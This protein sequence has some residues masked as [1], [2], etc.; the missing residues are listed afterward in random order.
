VEKE[1]IDR[2]GNTTDMKLFFKT[3][4]SR[5]KPKSKKRLRRGQKKLTSI[6]RCKA[7]SRSVFEEYARHL[8]ELKAIEPFALSEQ[9]PPF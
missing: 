7:V 9:C 5:S 1:E 2:R 3:K 6:S 8:D 4:R